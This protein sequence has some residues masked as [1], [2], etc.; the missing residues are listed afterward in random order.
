MDAKVQP[1]DTSRGHSRV[2]KDQLAARQRADGAGDSSAGGYVT[3]PTRDVGGLGRSVSLA[4][5]EQELSMAIYTP[6]DPP[7]SSGPTNDLGI[8]KKTTQRLG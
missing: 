8:P 4:Q 2:S 6:R 7:L 1:A 3:W 5:L